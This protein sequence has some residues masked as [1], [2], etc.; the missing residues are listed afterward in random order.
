MLLSP[1]LGLVTVAGTTIGW[2]VWTDTHGAAFEFAGIP[3]VIWSAAYL[4]AALLPGAVGLSAAARL[5]PSSRLAASYCASHGTC[6][7]CSTTRWPPSL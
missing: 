5:T 1:R 2:N 7:T 4:T 3:A 6:T